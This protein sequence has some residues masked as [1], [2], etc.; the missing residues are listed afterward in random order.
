MSVINRMLR[1][2]DK[3]QQQEPK[4]SYTPAA[5]APT[6]FPWGWILGA[7]VIA[8]ISVVAVMVIWQWA[9]DTE[10]QQQAEQ[11]TPQPVQVSE[12]AD[13]ADTP[14]TVDVTPPAPAATQPQRRMQPEPVA[15][16]QAPASSAPEPASPDPEPT[17]PEPELATA[18]VVDDTTAT[19]QMAVERV[20]LTAAELA[21]VKLKQAREALQKGQR[22]RAASLFEQVI[23]LAPDHVAAR[24]ELAA[25]WYGR[26]QIA[27]AL[28]VLEQGLAAQPTQSRWQLLYARILLEGGAYQQAY[29]ALA[30]IDLSSA[31]ANDLLQ[32]RATAA[33]QLGL[34]AEAATDYQALAERTEEARWWLAAAVAYEDA[35]ARDAA[36]EAYQQA[37]QRGG[38][39]QDA[40]RYAE[41]RINYLGD[42]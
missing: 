17:P 27:A 1:D 26:G 20:E 3:R 32:L 39:N 4:S 11:V 23:A 29:Q 28:A 16:E 36:L 13:V 37:L 18:E 34:F 6:P 22:E 21:E 30:T 19:Q 8:A 42:L 9:S 40:R 2:L 5:A 33:N 10:V 25:Y 7:F 24:S 35:N 12:T 31:Q 15:A 14:A 38:L 41:Q